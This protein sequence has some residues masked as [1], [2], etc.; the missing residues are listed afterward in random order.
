MVEE[1]CEMDE[2]VERQRASSG[3]W[4]RAGIGVVS[5]GGESHLTVGGP[6]GVAAI[7]AQDMVYAVMP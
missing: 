3:Q 6:S 4:P 1:P 2:A 5:G 7:V